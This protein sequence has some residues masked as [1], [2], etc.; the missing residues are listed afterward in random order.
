MNHHTI[1]Q[2]RLYNQRLTG[3]QL[4]TAEEVVGWLGAAQ[5]QEYGQ[6]RWALGLR[7]P[8]LT[9]EKVETAFAE[10]RILR[11][12]VMRPTWHFVTPEDI[13]WLL[14]LTAPR[15]KTAVGSYLRK[16]EI[17][18]ALCARSYDV[19][20]RELQGDK[21]MQRSELK[22]ALLQEGIFGEDDDRLRFTFL[23]MCAELDGIL[24]SGARQGKQHTYALLEERAPQ[25]RD[26]VRD[27]ALAEL[28]RRYF[29]SHGPATQYDFGWWSGLT[30]AQ[31]R[32]GIEMVRSHLAS[33]TVDDMV[34]WF[35]PDGA[36]PE[37]RSQDLRTQDTQT[38]LLPA[39]DEYLIAYKDRSAA[40][41]ETHK[42]KI[43]DNGLQTIVHEG[44]VIGLWNRKFRA[45]EVDVTLQPF[46]ALEE[47]QARGVEKALERYE[48]F[49]EI[50]VTVTQT[51]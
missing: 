4:E 49:L 13:R 18:D 11:T 27:E 30:L 39:L 33:E 2:Q 7:A 24:C 38:W 41:G 36:T 37:T 45:N 29:T 44:R 1:V 21:Q 20:V 8:G 25:G 14:Q 15:V 46:A 19:L 16:L 6:A 42:D 34:H 23:I 3:E 5:A 12:H 47:E 43:N 32:E 48:G 31:V 26:L 50:P 9:R 51:T 40:H 28:T 17:D 22:A 35:S 10:G